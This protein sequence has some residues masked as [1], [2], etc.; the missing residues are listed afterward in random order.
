MKVISIKEPWA[1][2]IK[3]NVKS[4]ETRSWNTKYR[5]EIYIHASLRKITNKHL[6]KYKEQISLLK[7]KDFK[8]GYIIA[9]ANLVD[10]QLMDEKF[11]EKVKSNHNEYICGFYEEGRYGWI[12]SKITVLENPIQVKGKLGIWNYECVL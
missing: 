9:K 10:C 8:Y 12:L 1:S 3:E 7:S 6:E 4:I 11:I 5:G 2:L